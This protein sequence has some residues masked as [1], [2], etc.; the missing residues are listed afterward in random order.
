M[1]SSL[2]ASLASFSL[3]TAADAAALRA[4]L[5][6]TDPASLPVL[7]DLTLWLGAAQAALADCAADA[8]VPKAV[9]LESIGVPPDTLRY[10]VETDTFTWDAS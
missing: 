6:A 9:L 7:D 8:G 4:S 10:C 1:T 5:A 2:P 3:A